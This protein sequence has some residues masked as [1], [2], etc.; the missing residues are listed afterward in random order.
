M[1][2][3]PVVNHVD[4]HRPP[5]PSDRTR[6]YRRRCTRRWGSAL[7]TRDDPAVDDE[8]QEFLCVVDAGERLEDDRPR[9]RWIIG[10]SGSEGFRSDSRLEPDGSRT[11]RYVE[12]GN[13]V[14]EEVELHD[15]PVSGSWLDRPEFGDWSR[16][17]DPTYGVPTEGDVDRRIAN[18]L[19]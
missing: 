7:R 12:S 13:P 14:G 10:V 11:V 3:A 6:C 1:T 18:R 8:Q 9:Q 15:A 4:R 5:R 16:L 2:A 17:S 19:S